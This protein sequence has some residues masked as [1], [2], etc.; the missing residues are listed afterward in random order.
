LADART[1][2]VTPLIIGPF[3]GLAMEMTATADTKIRA[4]DD[5]GTW[6][7]ADE[8]NLKYP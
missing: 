2:Q 8:T 7:G 6:A 4:V 3:S 1:V 5:G